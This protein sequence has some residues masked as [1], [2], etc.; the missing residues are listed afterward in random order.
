M[1]LPGE[2]LLHLIHQ[3]GLYFQRPS[4]RMPKP[5]R[6]EDETTTTLIP[7]NPPLPP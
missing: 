3:S 7:R 5:R 1:S 4:A 2:S 6:T